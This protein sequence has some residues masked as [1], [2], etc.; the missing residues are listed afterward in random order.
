VAS[1]QVAL[2]VVTTVGAGLLV[3]SVD[4]LGGLDLG[5]DQE[6][7]SV[8]SLTQPYSLFEVPSSY[9]QALDEVSRS[10]TGLPGIEAVTPTLNPPLTLNGGIDV[11][12]GLEGQT[13]AEFQASPYMSFEAVLPGYF[14][15]L[16]V[17]TV[18][19]RTLESRDGA[20]GTPV[21]V[22]S[23]GAARA[24]W[25]GRDPL[26]RQVNLRFPG[27]EET[28]WAVVG[29]V[30]DTRYRDLF[31]P[32]A[33][34][35]FP[36]PQMTAIPPSRLLVRTGSGGPTSVRAQ[37]D[38][39]FASVEPRVLVL[40]EERMRDVLARPAARPRFAAAVLVAFAVT[41]LLLAVL[42]VYGA[43]ATLVQE[44]TREM[45]LRRALG[46]PSGAVERVVLGGVLRVAAVGTLG[47]V[48]FSVGASR[49][50]G[51]LL[52]GVGATD[53]ATFA[54][55]ILGALGLALLAGVV[56]ARRAGRTDPGISLRVD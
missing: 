56:P 16:G 21:V 10:L 23:E 43:F 46:A 22:V 19:G 32:R 34:V 26:G 53:P 25:P 54:V 9:A 52:H 4:H 36:L 47:G 2:A 30:A 41:T 3:R 7:L 6:G 51:S 17:P 40:R 5:F 45:G 42:G 15:A 18:R 27:H 29:V 37:V 39:A 33:S 11:V 35:Y 1:F 44:R 38:E 20:G 12:V 14:A 28:W 50:V 49:W 31:E 55:V 8:V 48:L 13:D 24:L